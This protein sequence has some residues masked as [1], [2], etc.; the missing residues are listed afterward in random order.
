MQLI[1]FTSPKPNSILW[2]VHYCLD[3]LIFVFSPSMRL[4]RHVL[5]NQ[6]IYLFTVFCVLLISFLLLSLYLLDWYYYQFRVFNIKPLPS[7]CIIVLPTF[8]GFINVDFFSSSSNQKSILI[9]FLLLLTQKS[10][11]IIIAINRCRPMHLFL[12]Q[13]IP[14]FT[15]S[16][17]LFY[18]LGLYFCV[19]L[20][21]RHHL[22]ICIDLIFLTLLNQQII[23]TS[24][25]IAIFLIVIFI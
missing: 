4:Q 5:L 12:N 1:I 18:H 10:I 14:R 2:I 23:I 6:S 9:F 16:I 22:I 15:Y 17:Q 24:S 8:S 25:F 19:L 21:S 20:I 13:I 7:N 3:S 11:F